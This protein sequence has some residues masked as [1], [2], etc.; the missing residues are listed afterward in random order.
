MG[1]SKPSD[2]DKTSQIRDARPSRREALIGT[3]A[4]GGTSLA[5]CSSGGNFSSSQNSAPIRGFEY[6]VAS[7]DPTVSSI[8]IWTRA[9]PSGPQATSLVRLQWDMAF[10]ED[11]ETIAKSGEIETD[12]SRD[13]TA[14]IN[15]TGLEAGKT[16]YYRFKSDQAISPI[17]RTKTLPSSH[18]KKLRLAVVSCNSWQ[19]GFFN[20]LDHIARN[21]DFD[22][23]IHLGDYI[24][25]YGN[26][27]YGGDIGKEIGRQHEPPREIISLKDYRK[28]HAQYKSDP[29]MQA[30]HA[31]HPMILLWD[32]HEVANNSWEGGAQNHNLDEGDWAERRRAAMQAYYEWMPVR[33]PEP[34]KTREALYRAYNFGD[35]ATLVTIETRLTARSEQILIEDYANGFKTQEDVEQFRQ[36]VLNDPDRY[37]LGQAQIDFIEKSLRQS[38]R[39]GQPW[40]L[41]GN[42]ILMAKI[43]IPDLTPFV[44]EEVIEKI[45]KDWSGIRPF[46]ETSKYR[47]PLYLDTWSGYPNA[48]ERFYAACERA[49]ATDLVVLTGD[50]HEFW[51]NDLYSDKGKKIGIELGTTSLTSATVEQYLG[52]G[53][54]DFALLVTKENPE[55]RYYDPLHKGYI[56]LTLTRK[57]G[58]AKYIALSTVLDTDYKVEMSASFTFKP[59]GDSVSFTGHKGLGFKEWFLWRQKSAPLGS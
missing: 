2:K 53:T 30:A 56:D 31:M 27:G 8:V 45:E 16:Y 33:D 12:Q 43:N 39:Q 4:L 3:A 48:R 19:H 55:A 32:D 59:K 42:Q 23:V 11:F 47:F 21:P 18:V 34:G 46:V 6:G 44:S 9:A 28:R 57:K 10:D 52:D 25:E 1:K 14:K 38:K 5:A 40:R 51:T 49:G 17:G 50:A 26:D 37:M 54:K 35:L 24:Y 29:A 36:K 22:A 41:I 20:G 15:V 7:G 58:V 13:W